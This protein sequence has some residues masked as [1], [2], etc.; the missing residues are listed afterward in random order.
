MVLETLLRG[1]SIRSLAKQLWPSRRT[2]GRWWQ[3]L[4]GRVDAYGL[5]LRSRFA[6]LGRAGDAR[7]FWSACFERMSL[8]EAMGWLDTAGVVVP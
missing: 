8:G 7:G 5:H 2:I 3:W 1:W 4:R 6:E